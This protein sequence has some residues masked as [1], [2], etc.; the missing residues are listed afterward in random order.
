MCSV[1][2]ASDALAQLLEEAGIA[3]DGM[4]QRGVLTFL[5]DDRPQPWEVHGADCLDVKLL[6]TPSVPKS[7]AVMAVSALMAVKWL[8]RSFPRQQLRRSANRIR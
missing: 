6:Q 7:G 5:F 1:Q 4:T 3:A 2:A 8:L